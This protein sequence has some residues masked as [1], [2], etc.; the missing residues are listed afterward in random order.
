MIRTRC[1][2]DCAD[3]FVA[4]NA[5]VIYSNGRRPYATFHTIVSGAQQFELGPGVPLTRTILANTLRALES[6][7]RRRSTSSGY[8][9][10]DLVLMTRHHIGWWVPAGPQRKTFQTL[11]EL[12]GVYP[13]PPLLFVAA[14]H[15]GRAD[16]LR[17][18]ALRHNE[19]PSLETALCRA[20][21]SNLFASNGVCLGSTELPQRLEPDDTDAWTR[22][23]FR[24]AFTGGTKEYRQLWE[25]LKDADRFPVDILEDANATLSGV[26]EVCQRT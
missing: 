24:S 22:A 23:Y 20:P 1:E 14:R 13:Q 21:Y 17:V 25:P 5:L 15:A 6:E 19:R 8:I 10:S 9:P 16:R 3:D 4:R 7:K 12:N 26:I 2:L 11:P 18:F